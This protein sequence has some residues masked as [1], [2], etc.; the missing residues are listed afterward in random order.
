MC[1]KQDRKD[2]KKQIKGTQQCSQ[3]IGGCEVVGSSAMVAGV[4]RR[5]GR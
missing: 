2:G 3:T 1:K 5:A 4:T